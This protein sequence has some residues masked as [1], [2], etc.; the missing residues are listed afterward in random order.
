MVVFLVMTAP[1]HGSH[2]S[3]VGF[4][5]PGGPGYPTVTRGLKPRLAVLGQDGPIAYRLLGPIWAAAEGDSA[6]LERD[7]NAEPMRMAPVIRSLAR[8][9]AG[10]LSAWAARSSKY[11]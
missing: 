11:A 2:R 10:R 3:S 8:R 7:A 9:I 5:N 1:R 4:R 6:V